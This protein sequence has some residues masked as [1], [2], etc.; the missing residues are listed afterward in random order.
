MPLNWLSR[1]IVRLA[2]PSLQFQ[3]ISSL[4]PKLPVDLLV[5]FLLLLQNPLN[6]LLSLSLYLCLHSTGMNLRPSC[7]KQSLCSPVKN[8][9]QAIRLKRLQPFLNLLQNAFT[10]VLILIEQMQS[11]LRKCL[12]LCPLKMIH[13]GCDTI[14]MECQ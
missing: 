7:S 12:H 5:L 9:V 11:S 2:Q 1:K 13:N 4:L 10:W 14:T 3:V 8:S 6:L